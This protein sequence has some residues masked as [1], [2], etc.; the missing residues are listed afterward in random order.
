VRQLDLEV[1]HTRKNTHVICKSFRKMRNGG[2][3][4]DY[5]GRIVV[6]REQCGI[7][8]QTKN[9]EDTRGSRCYGTVLP[10][11]PLLDSI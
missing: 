10:T 7:F 2:R 9:C 5:S 4:V 3:L 8:A 1:P 6:R 11:L